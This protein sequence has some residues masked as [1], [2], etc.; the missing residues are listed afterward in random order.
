MS[1]SLIITTREELIARFEEI[2]STYSAF[3]S[4]VFPELRLERQNFLPK[5]Q[6]ELAAFAAQQVADKRLEKERLI[7]KKAGVT[8]AYLEKERAL[9]ETQETLVLAAEEKAEAALLNLTAEAQE[10]GMQK[11]AWYLKNHTEISTQKDKAILSYI[12]EYNEKITALNQ[13]KRREENVYDA[14]I[15]VAEAAYE[16][17]LNEKQLFLEKQQEEQQRAVVEFNNEQAHKEVQYNLLAQQFVFERANEETV[18]RTSMMY[19]KLQACYAYL[20]N[21]TP[22]EAFGYVRTDH[23]YEKYL[24]IY[25]YETLY[26][27][28]KNMAGQ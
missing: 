7:A 4:A 21:F 8:A 6:E 17:A 16:C 24:G 9:Y 27:R 22:L 25:G 26:D 1:E 3:Y 2:E 28:Y 23:I 19:E 12:E 14:E 20:G 10:R 11:S 18:T 15:A 13:E 5:T